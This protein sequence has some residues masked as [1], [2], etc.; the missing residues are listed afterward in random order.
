M[1]D[2]LWVDLVQTEQKVASNDLDV[3]QVKS[4]AAIY[5]VFKEI[6]RTYRQFKLILLL[7][8]LRDSVHLL[9][10]LGFYLSHKRL[11][12]HAHRLLRN[13]EEHIGRFVHPVHL[14]HVQGLVKVRQVQSLLHDKLLFLFVELWLLNSCQSVYLGEIRY[15]SL[16]FVHILLFI[17]TQLGLTLTPIFF[18]CCSASWNCFVDWEVW[19]F[20]FFR[21]LLLDLNPKDVSVGCSL[22]H[23]KN[24]VLDLDA[25]LGHKYEA[26][27]LFKFIAKRPARSLHWRLD[28]ASVAL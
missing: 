4:F 26:C 6:R 8:L 22:H 27:T 11:A 16:A 2:S 20:T 10:A 13:E 14:T 21:G 9:G 15:C 12:H 19:L 28:T 18:A 1:C 3:A 17:L 7:D 24:S 5:Y 23:L 25:L